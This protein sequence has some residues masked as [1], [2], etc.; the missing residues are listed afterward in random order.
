MVRLKK[1]ML[2]RLLMPKSCVAR[3]PRR[4]PL[5]I[6]PRGAIAS[7]AS[8]IIALAISSLPK[9]TTPS[10][11]TRAAF[12]MEAVI[13]EVGKVQ[14]DKNSAC[15][16]RNSHEGIPEKYYCKTPARFGAGEWH[17]AIA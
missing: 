2:G 16:R 12:Y 6:S 1:K 7:E 10:I 4:A 14:T 5:V 9:E 11:P 15:A 3:A 17:D 8:P 13:R